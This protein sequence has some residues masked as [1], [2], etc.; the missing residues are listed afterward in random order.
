M[1]VTWEPAVVDAHI[2]FQCSRWQIP[3]VHGSSNSG[4]GAGDSPGV[5]GVRNEATPL[6]LLPG[7]GALS[8]GAYDT[9]NADIQL[10]SRNVVSMPG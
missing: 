4:E 9:R 8:H 10:A 6:T 1:G 5:Y 7:T 3:N 2:G